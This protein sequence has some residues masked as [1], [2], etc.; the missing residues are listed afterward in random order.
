MFFFAHS[1]CYEIAVKSQ[2]FNVILY[3]SGLTS[4]Q[5]VQMFSIVIGDY[6]ETPISILRERQVA[7]SY[8]LSG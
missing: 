1:Y 6:N 8:L 3:W 2:N 4:A 7:D 5:F